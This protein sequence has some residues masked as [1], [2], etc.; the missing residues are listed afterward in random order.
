MKYCNL[1]IIYII[2]R[3]KDFGQIMD[4]VGH[5]CDS[6]DESGTAVILIFQIGVK[7]IVGIIKIFEI[8]KFQLLSKY[9]T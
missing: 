5:I 7:K 3:K 8:S 2:V 1:Y 9:F 6:I 4:I